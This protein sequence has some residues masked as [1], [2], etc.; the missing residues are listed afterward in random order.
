MPL[1][2]D[3]QLTV[4]SLAEE[5]GLRRNKLTHKHTGL[6]DLFY[7][8]I[9]AQDVQPKA[10]DAL[11]RNNN[12]LTARLKKAR[13]ECDQL[14]TQVK[15][16]VRVIQVLEVENHQLRESAGQ[17]GVVRVLHQR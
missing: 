16:L 6:K 13:E 1:R 3:G 5:A 2:S 14:Q 12:E 17:D 15:Q 7:A 11:K 8:L 9:R 4:K 10:A